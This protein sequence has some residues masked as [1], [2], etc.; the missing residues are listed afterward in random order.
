M[1]LTGRVVARGEAASPRGLILHYEIISPENT[2][3]NLAIMAAESKRWQGTLRDYETQR[4]RGLMAPD[5]VRRARFADQVLAS[6]SEY[7]RLAVCCVLVAQGPNDRILGATTYAVF[8]TNEG[9]ISL[10]AIDA[11]HLAGS[12]GEGQLRGIGTAL[13]AAV[14]RQMLSRGVQT[15]YLHPLDPAAAVFWIRRGFMPCGVG[16]RMCVRGSDAI[17]RLIEG[18]TATPDAPDRG[19]VIMCGVPKAV[20]VYVPTVVPGG[21]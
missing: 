21:P 5:V 7:V 6:A 12:P 1:P 17:G 8:G 9:A 15:L 3:G 11:R 2:V 20:R 14:S 13:T 19:E 10:Q 4:D 18:C 16:G